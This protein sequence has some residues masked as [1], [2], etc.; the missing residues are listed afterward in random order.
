MSGHIEQK[1][2]DEDKYFNSQLFF[3]SKRDKEKDNDLDLIDQRFS[4]D[5]NGTLQTK[6][7]ECLPQGLLDSIE[8]LS[9]LIIAKYDDNDDNKEVYQTLKEVCTTD[10]SNKESNCNC[11]CI[12]AL[13]R[14]ESIASKGKKT[15]KKAKKKSLKERDGDWTC[16]YCQNLNF[17]FRQK[18]NRCFAFK[19]NS[20]QCHDAHMKAVLNI[21]NENEKIRQSNMSN[22]DN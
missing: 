12:Y 3:F 4:Y 11:N 19:N 7:K 20:D 13:N 8:K 10:N 14:I 18:C 6:L 21:I 1:Q 9:P 16:Y 15:N 22:Q 17:A 5:A 2:Y